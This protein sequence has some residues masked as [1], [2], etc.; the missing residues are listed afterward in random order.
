MKLWWCVIT[1]IVSSAGHTINVDQLR[2]IKQYETYCLIA[3][4]YNPPFIY[5]DWTCEEVEKAIIDAIKVG[6]NK[7]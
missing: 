7:S 2:Y 3:Q 6:C 4:Y 5:S 1:A